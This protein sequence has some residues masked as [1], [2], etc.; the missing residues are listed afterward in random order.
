MK[1]CNQCK[2]GSHFYKWN[3]TFECAVDISKQRLR[4]TYDIRNK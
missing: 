4:L 1:K 2:G 3:E